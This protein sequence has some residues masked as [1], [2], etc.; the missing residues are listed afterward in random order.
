MELTAFRRVRSGEN[1]RKGWL[2][3]LH[4]NDLREDS[5]ISNVNGHAARILG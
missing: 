3:V 2:K 1:R 5:R 4:Y